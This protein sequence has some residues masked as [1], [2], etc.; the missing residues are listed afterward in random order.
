MLVN[1]NSCQKK[2]IV[3]D[4]AITETGRLLQCG[5]CGNKWT[6]YPVKLEPTKK[7]KS[8]EKTS[9]LKPTKVK[10]IKQN[11]LKTS[12]KKK[13][14]EINLY[15]EEYLKKKHGLV[16]K[17]KI[18]IKNGNVNK[19][20]SNSSNFFNYLMILTILLIALFGIL[21]LTRDFITAS[22]PFTESYINSLFEVLEILKTTIS[23]I[24]N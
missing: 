15:S 23:S 3:P 8:N 16:I 11:K 12:T 5:S 19:K 20:N 2:F 10:N 4:S 6:Q 7:E 14:R 22:Y 18:D 13:K 24:L 21:N 1:C 9:K 17:D